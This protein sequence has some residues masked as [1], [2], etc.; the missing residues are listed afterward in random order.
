[1]RTDMK[2]EVMVIKRNGNREPFD[3]EKI[4]KVIS[5]AGVRPVEAAE[6]AE[7]I[8]SWIE[9]LRQK[10]VSSIAIRDRVFHELEGV[11]KYASGLYAWYQ[12]LKDK[13]YQAPQ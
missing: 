1:M 12:N 8:S 6:V 13:K 4:T 9:S 5:A 10:E 2:D 11:D 3:P 7:K